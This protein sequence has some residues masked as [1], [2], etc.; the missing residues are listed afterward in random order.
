MLFGVLPRGFLDPGGD[1]PV[2]DPNESSFEKSLRLRQI[3]LQSAQAAILESRIA[4]A[5][6]SR[7]ERLAV[8]DMIPG[9]TKVE[10]FRE[11]GSGQGWRGPAT[12]LQINE[13]AGNAVID[14]QG[15]PYLMGLRHIR[16]LRDSFLIY[17]NDNSTL[18]STDV[19]KAVSRMKRVV[20]QCTPF[21][22]Y[23]MGEIL[24][25]KG[26]F[27]MVK[28]PKGESPTTEQ[29]LKDAKMV[30]DFHYDHF[31]LNGI[32]F[33]RGMKTILT[34]KYSKG[35]LLTWP[36]GT[37]GFAL[38]ENHSD[39][40][41]HIKEYLQH[42]IDS[43]CHLYLFGYVKYNQEET[44][45]PARI[46]RRKPAEPSDQGQLQDEEMEEQAELKRKGPDSRTVISA[47]EKKKQKTYWTSTELLHQRSI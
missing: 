30:L 45:I 1:Q 39:A 37:M 2:A 44:S 32:R 14:S 24:K 31:T 18:T 35:V 7:P 28:F 17:L 40:H 4:R 47:P 12:I 46:T 15:K 42:N 16:P 36:C 22:P 41:I 23:T 43:L 8:E 5:N 6:R 19:E 26:E 33:G 3:A 13:E 9:T 25:E 34:P 27:K 38:T 29:M 11:D 21:K 10:I 20:E